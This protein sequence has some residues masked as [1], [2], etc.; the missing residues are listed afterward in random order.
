MTETYFG[1]VHFENEES[2]KDVTVELSNIADQKLPFQIEL[3]N[4]TNHY[5]LGENKVAN[6][7]LVCEYHIVKG[8]IFS[9]E[10]LQIFTF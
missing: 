4:P 1:T 5:Q 8:L 3:S 10:V 6:I 7:S 9:F 2:Q